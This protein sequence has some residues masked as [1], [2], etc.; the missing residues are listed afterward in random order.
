MCAARTRRFRIL[1]LVEQ[2]AAV[3][4]GLAR[5]ARA[6]VGLVIGGGAAARAAVGTPLDPDEAKLVVAE[7]GLHPTRDESLD[8]TRLAPARDDAHAHAQGAVV[9][10]LLVSADR[11]RGGKRVVHRGDAEPERLVEHP[12]HAFRD[13]RL[14][15]ARVDAL[16]EDV[17]GRLAHE[18]GEAAAAGHA[19]E[20]A[21]GRVGGVLSDAAGGKGGGI[22]QPEVTVGAQDE[23]RPAAACGIELGEARVAPAFALVVAVADEPL[24]GRESPHPLIDRAEER[25]LRRH[26]ARAQLPPFEEPDGVGI[27][28][29][30]GIDDARDSAPTPEVD[31]TRPGADQVVDRGA[32]PHLEDA[33]VARHEAG[34][35]PVLRIERGDASVHERELGLKHRDGPVAASFLYCE[36][37]AIARNLEMGEP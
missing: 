27:G 29:T 25:L 2:H 26:E 8:Q 20:A 19:I 22:G 9:L 7:A 34:G 16:E 18:A 15:V 37:Y 36:N 23:E 13:L 33:P 6:G 24:P 35:R 11:A 14:R 31:E 32:L 4:L 1:R 30:M 3:V 12:R 10:H 28:V 5:H 21:E 17:G